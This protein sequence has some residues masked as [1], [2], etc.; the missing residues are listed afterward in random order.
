[1]DAAISDPFMTTWKG[2]ELMPFNDMIWIPFDPDEVRVALDPQQLA[3]Y[4]TFD[5]LMRYALGRRKF[6]D[7]QASKGQSRRI[8]SVDAETDGLYGE[9]FA[10]GAVV[11]DEEGNEVARFAGTA[12]PGS[13]KDQWVRENV[14]P[15]LGPGVDFPTRLELREAF[16]EFWVSHREGAL[17]VADVGTPVEAFLF[18][19]CVGDDPARA[20]DGPFPVHELATLLLAGGLNPLAERALLASRWGV[21]WAGRPHNPLDDA[22]VA[23][24]LFRCGLRLFGPPSDNLR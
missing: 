18:R 17:C 21:E 2:V 11:L 9:P 14:L 20:K 8:F 10:V 22:R 1:M 7:A 6:F 5:E 13:V 3:Q 24:L 16:W 19:L 4:G 12:D 23:A 15:V